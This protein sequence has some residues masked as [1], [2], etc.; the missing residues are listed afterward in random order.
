[1]G[2]VFEGSVRQLAGGHAQHEVLFALDD[3]HVAHGET[4][5]KGDRDKG[6]ELVFISQ[7]DA[8]FRYFHGSPHTVVLI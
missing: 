6:L 4:F 8:D 5:V 2:H 1:V 3:L 7:G